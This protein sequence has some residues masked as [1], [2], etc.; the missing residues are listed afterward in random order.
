MS[1]AGGA[2]TR[3]PARA[4]LGRVT[5]VAQHRELSVGTAIDLVRIVDR[6]PASL[7]AQV[8]W[9]RPLVREAIARLRER[10][11]T[12]GRIEAEVRALAKLSLRIASVVM[13]AGTAGELAA[14]Q[15][16]ASDALRAE[17]PAGLDE[18]DRD[19][20][21][22]C[23]GITESAIRW[24]ADQAEGDVLPKEDPEVLVEAMLAGPGSGP[25][26]RGQMLLVAAGADPSF[27]ATPEDTA[28]R[29]E[30]VS[31]AFLALSAAADALSAEG[32]TLEPFPDASDDE[33][34]ARAIRAAASAR[35]ALTEEDVR[36]LDD[37][38]LRALR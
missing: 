20:F 26:L 15:R 30:L 35:R 2:A 8:L 14:I 16:S 13:Q 7:R 1:A 17:G 22:W 11:L 33:R 25:F 38:R 5:G 31:E 12:E 24:M 23:V 19:T 21:A 37:A 29:S 9:T 3:S 36:A 32:V 27:P 34:G 6:L 28:A 4:R 18:D 10:P